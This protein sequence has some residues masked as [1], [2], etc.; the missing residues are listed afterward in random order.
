MNELLPGR[1]PTEVA[2]ALIAQDGPEFIRHPLDHPHMWIRPS[3]HCPEGEFSIIFRL[4]TNLPRGHL[5][6]I[7]CGLT[8]E[9]MQLSYSETEETWSDSGYVMAYPH[10]NYIGEFGCTKVFMLSIVFSVQFQSALGRMEVK[11]LRSTRLLRR[12]G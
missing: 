1:I 10:A 2:E 7:Y 5:M 3:Y 9:V 11:R 6:G 8:N 4:D 12:F